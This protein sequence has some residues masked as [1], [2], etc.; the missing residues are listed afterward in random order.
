VGHVEIVCSGDVRL[1]ILCR[2]LLRVLRVAGS[3]L[4]EP[5]R[6]Q[7]L[8]GEGL[9]AFAGIEIALGPGCGLCG[10]WVWSRG[11]RF[12]EARAGRSEPWKGRIWMLEEG[13]DA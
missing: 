1:E 10:T 5:R 2:A 3:D 8:C 6:C 11:A 9:G 7:E 4:H 13:R 12:E